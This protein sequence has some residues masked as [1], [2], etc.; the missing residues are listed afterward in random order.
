M[1]VRRLEIDAAA[2]APII[3]LAVLPAPGRA[4]EGASGVAHA[5]EDRVEFRVRDME[6]VMASG[7]GLAVGEEK[8]QRL[9]HEHRGKMI[10]RLLE[11]HI[12][13][14]GEPAR[15][16]ALVVGGHDRMVED[17]GHRYLGIN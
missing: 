5:R 15:G 3:E 13:H 1:A 17:D 12:E 4:A 10:V 2:A 7:E 14:A 11:R 9:V 16:G 6:G 8:G